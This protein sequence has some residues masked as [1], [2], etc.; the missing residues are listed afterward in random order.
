MPKLLLVIAMSLA[1]ISFKSKLTIPDS[2]RAAG[3]RTKIWSQ[4]QNKLR[5][6]GLRDDQPVYLRLFKQE[7]LLEVW[8]RSGKQYKLFDKYVICF[9]SGGLGTK[10]KEN[11]GKSP[12][13]FYTITPKQ[14]QPVSQFHL[15]MNVGY[16]NAYDKQHG[17]TGG[18]IMIHGNCVSIGCYAMS[19]Y[20]IDEIYTLV[21]EAFVHGQKS[22]QVAIFP[23][24]M[25]NKNIEAYAKWTPIR[26]WRN[27]KSGYDMF[28]RTHIPPVVSVANKNYAFR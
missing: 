12:E 22:V 13:G 16:P 21:Y 8:V 10:T 4:L 6:K 24:E 14:L 3:V 9:Y 27:M 11:D 19:D 17:Y 2:P 25:T 15:A 1:L 23:F 18:D 28:E 20:N 5:K 26:F 7:H